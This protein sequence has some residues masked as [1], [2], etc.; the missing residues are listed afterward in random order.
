MLISQLGNAKDVIGRLLA[1]N[2]LEKRKTKQSVEALVSAMNED[3]HYGVRRGAATALRRIGTDRAFQSLVSSWSNQKDARVR[4]T[5][6][7]QITRFYRPAAKTALLK[8]ADSESNPAIAS[9]AIKGLGKYQDGDSLAA[10]KRALRHESFGNRVA[11]AAVA[12]LGDYAD[13]D[14]AKDLLKMLD[15]RHKDFSNR[16]FGRALRTLGSLARELDDRD[17]VREF[18][19][20]IASDPNSQVRGSAIDALGNLGDRRV[21]AMLKSLSDD[22]QSDRVSSAAKSALQKLSAEERL[23]PKEVEELRRQL[24]ELRDSQT[25]LEEQLIEMKKVQSAKKEKANP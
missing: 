15:D 5:V 16:G 8:V 18:L 10:I 21:A 13:P 20:D 11:L 9:E 24:A 3:G 14:Q 19:N 25:K 2:G 7:Q 6:V 12:A 22:E 1:V 4:Q 17:D 23:V